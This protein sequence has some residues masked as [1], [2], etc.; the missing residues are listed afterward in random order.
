MAI[1]DSRSGFSSRPSEGKRYEAKCF[2]CK[3][4]CQVPFE[5]SGDKPIYCK[6]CFDDMR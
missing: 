5:P 4:K 3:E 6:E 2:K 1:Y